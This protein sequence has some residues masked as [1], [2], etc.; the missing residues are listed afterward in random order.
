MPADFWGGWVLLLTAASVLGLAWFVWSI[1]FGNGAAAAGECEDA[2]PVWDGSLRE[3]SQPAPM[4]WFWLLFASLVFT[5]IYLILYPGLGSFAGTLKWSQGG[6]LA[7]SEAAWEARF[8]AD[9]RAV[10]A[11]PL[12]ALQADAGRMATAAGIYARQCAACH[13]P[14][15]EGQ[16]RLF[17]NLRDTQWQWGGTAADIER[18][19]R[20]GRQAVMVGWGAVLGADGVAAVADYVLRLPDGVPEEHAGKGRYQQFCVACHGLSGE[21]Q[22]LL[23]APALTDAAYLYGGDRAAVEASIR[24]GRSG[25]MPAFEG[26]LDA[27]QIRLLVA[28]LL[29]ERDAPGHTA[30]PGA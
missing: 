15:A 13:G 1:Y 20:G 25:E 17:P 24:D 14:D 7:A 6:R 8:G 23:G 11:A 16:A 22:T 28:W 26:R 3:G 19:I 21:G 30:E 4:W 9:R 5:V 18:T 2:S 29:L 27:A 10:A 12:A